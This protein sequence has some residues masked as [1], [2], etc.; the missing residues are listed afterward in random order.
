MQ[1]EK[2]KGNKKKIKG[3]LAESYGTKE[4]AALKNAKILPSIFQ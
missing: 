2:L 3:K 4:N 1:K